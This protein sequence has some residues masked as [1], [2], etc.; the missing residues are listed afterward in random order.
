MHYFNILL[1]FGLAILAHPNIIAMDNSIVNHIDP[2]Q[3]ST[4]QA[5]SRWL[6][7]VAHASTHQFTREINALSTTALND[8]INFAPTSF[9]NQI[10]QKNGT[11]HMCR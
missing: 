5:T 10:K 11:Y 8:L 9:T 7:I 1:A 6:T 3:L 2:V 4:I